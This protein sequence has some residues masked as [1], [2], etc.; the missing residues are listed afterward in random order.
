[1]TLIPLLL[2]ASQ[3]APAAAPRQ[4]VEAVKPIRLVSV[5]LLP[6]AVDDPS[7]LLHVRKMFVGRFELSRPARH[8]RLD[9]VASFPATASADGDAPARRP[10]PR[11]LRRVERAYRPDRGARGTDEA[12]VT[13]GEFALMFYDRPAALERAG[14]DPPRTTPTPSSALHLHLR[15]GG[16]VRWSSSGSN[17]A[18]T[19][20]I[21]DLRDGLAVTRVGDEGL[22]RVGPQFLLCRRRW[23]SGVSRSAAADARSLRELAARQPE[24]AF[25]GL[26]L[27]VSDTS[28]RETV[29]RRTTRLDAAA[30]L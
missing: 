3:I 5:S 17:D 14:L 7:A 18:V 16:H 24:A 20:R 19:A 29:L 13:G 4:P 1:M 28:D 8:V 27:T 9:A 12:G 25:L 6:R 2:A 10:P 15:T 30:G 26:V 23:G 11:L 22:P 21:L